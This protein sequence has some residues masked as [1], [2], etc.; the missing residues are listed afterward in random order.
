MIQVE[1]PYH[2]TVRAPRSRIQAWDVCL[3][4]GRTCPGGARP[5]EKR[6]REGTDVK[7]LVNKM[8]VAWRY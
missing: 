7:K 6:I 2:V 4:N 8:A 1:A 3:T 5:D